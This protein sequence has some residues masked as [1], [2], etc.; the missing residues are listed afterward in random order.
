MELAVQSLEQEFNGAPPEKEWFEQMRDLLEVADGAASLHRRGILH[1]DLRPGNILR[2][3]DG[4]LVVS[5]FGLAGPATNTATDLEPAAHLAPEC[6]LG[7]PATLASDVWALGLILYRLFFFAP[8][9]W[10]SK[11]E[12][13]YVKS[14]LPAA[15]TPQVDAQVRTVCLS[16]LAFDPADR[17][18]DAAQVREQLARIIEGWNDVIVPRPNGIELVPLFSGSWDRIALW[19]LTR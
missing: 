18:R 15:R 13:P 1:R 17:P 10:E 16:C 6:V 9:R 4:R 7:A 8:P 14:L 3:A 11:G 2:M 19:A 5:D 12:A